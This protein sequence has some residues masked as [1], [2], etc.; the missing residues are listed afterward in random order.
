MAKKKK[1]K[2]KRTTTA[3]RAPKGYVLFSKKDARE[4]ERALKLAHRTIQRLVDA[5]LVKLK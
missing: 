4:I 3:P 1:K 5:G 2:K